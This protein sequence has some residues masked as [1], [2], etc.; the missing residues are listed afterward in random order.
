MNCAV[1]NRLLTFLIKPLYRKI[2]T[3]PFIFTSSP[4]FPV[5]H[6]TGMFSNEHSRNSGLPI[7]SMAI[8]ISEKCMLEFE[9]LR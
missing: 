1:Y 9:D 8:P 7:F 6:W 2:Y 5:F 3:Y 4:I